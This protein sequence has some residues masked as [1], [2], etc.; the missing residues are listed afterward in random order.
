MTLDDSYVSNNVL[1]TTFCPRVNN[2]T[3]QEKIAGD[4][5]YNGIKLNLSL[6]S[7]E[8]HNEMGEMIIIFSMNENVGANSKVLTLCCL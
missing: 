7:L 8:I 3:S 6:G 1:A 5:L 2:V 4:S